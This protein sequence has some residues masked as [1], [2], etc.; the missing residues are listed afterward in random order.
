VDANQLADAPRGGGAG[1]GRRLHR[2]DVAADDRG[3]EAGVDL[4]PADEDDVG[5]LH[6]RV[7]RFDHADEAARLDHAERVA[8]LAFLTGGG[9]VGHCR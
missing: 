3:D 2:S 7:G 9:R 5:G 4:L 1:V 6:H 8:D